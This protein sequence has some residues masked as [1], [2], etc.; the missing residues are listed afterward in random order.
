MRKLLLL[1]GAAMALLVLQSCD[2][3][4]DCIINS[5][6]HLPHKNLDDGREGYFYEDVIRAEIKN[7]PRDNDYWYYFSVRG[8]PRGMEYESIGTD[9][10]IYGTPSDPGRYEVQVFVEVEPKILFFDDDDSWDEDGDDLCS[11]TDE[12]FYSF[13]V[14]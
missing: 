3:A 5:R 8:L 4:T 9:L 1:F 14:F 11:Y 10:F 2:N 7:E 6:P 13:Q 12:R